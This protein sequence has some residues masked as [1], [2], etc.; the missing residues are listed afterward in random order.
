MTF[1]VSP[2][3]PRALMWAY[4]YV[5]TN[6][7]KETRWRRATKGGGSKENKRQLEKTAVKAGGLQD[8]GRRRAAGETGSEADRLKE[9]MGS[10]EESRRK[11]KKQTSRLSCS[12]LPHP[13]PA[14]SYS[15]E[16]NRRVT[17]CHL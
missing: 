8:G 1:P 14:G 11:E 5:D 6:A 2:P 3:S 15:N 16:C 13:E 12:P 17:S 9:M 10:T 4:H 7:V